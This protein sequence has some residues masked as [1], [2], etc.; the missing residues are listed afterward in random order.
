[1]T[2]AAAPPPKQ[3]L[4]FAECLEFVPASEREGVIERA[5]IMQHDGGESKA[6]AEM[7]ALL[8]WK[9]RRRKADK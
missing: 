2:P 1:M 7:N 5:A 8:D 6:D 4:S 3:K 9:N